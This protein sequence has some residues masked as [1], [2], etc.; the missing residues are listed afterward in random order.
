MPGYKINPSKSV[1]FLYS[2]NK[3][4]EKE[5]RDTTPFTKVTNNTK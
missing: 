5:S 1:A 4:A 3:Q 2:N